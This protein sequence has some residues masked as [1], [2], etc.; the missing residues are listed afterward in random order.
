MQFCFDDSGKLKPYKD[1]YYPKPFLKW[2]GGKTQLIPTIEKHFPNCVK[3]LASVVSPMQAHAMYIKEHHKNAKVVFI[4]PCIS[5]KDEAEKSS[6]NVDVVLTFEE[7]ENWLNDKNVELSQNNINPHRKRANF[8]PT[9]GGI[10]RSMELDEKRNYIVIDGMEDCIKTLNEIENGEST[11][12]FIEMS[13]CKG[14]CIGGPV[15]KKLNK[16][17]AISNIAIQKDIELEDYDIE[18]SSD[19]SINKE[20]NAEVIE[21]SN[22]NSEEIEQI[23]RKMGKT[24]KKDELNC[25]TCG[26]N[27]CREK[28]IAVL[29]GKAEISMCLPFLK[30]KAESLSDTIITNTPNGIMVL[31]EQFE[32]QQINDSAKRIF[33][34]P[35]DENVKGKNVSEFINPTDYVV[36]VE[37]KKVYNKLKYLKEYDK[38]VEETITYNQEYHIVMS[39]MKDVTEEQQMIL[40]KRSQN[41]IAIDITNKV[42]EKQMRVVH[43]IASILGETTA[44]TKIALTKLK[45]TLNDE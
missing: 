32:I 26:Y 45:E 13:A 9:S 17:L 27:T 44:E 30:E 3:Y 38:Y 8:F 35:I 14:S 16:S 10:L 19:I 34:I 37:D 20:F 33:N 29:Q 42:V 11:D 7:L 43:E 36:A 23:L 12:C 39:I 28:A 22:L 1:M 25:G 24:S 6:G 18:G 4:G 5:K 21:K 31:N 2:A 40:E 41:Q 15:M